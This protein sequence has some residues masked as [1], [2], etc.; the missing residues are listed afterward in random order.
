M[1]TRSTAPILTRI[2]KLCLA[3]PDATEKLS[4]GTPCFFA[5]QGSKARCFAMWA[6]NHH[7]D[8]RL[9][10]WVAATKVVQHAQV[11]ARPEQF[12]VP[13]YVGPRGWL[14]V[15]LDRK[16]AWDEIA[17]V[18]EDAFLLVAR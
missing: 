8:G 14:G 5:G 12:F 17:R 2:R 11:T 16:L 18:L 9:A 10:V 13:P 3:F 7:D 15:R 4:H 1:T 6:D